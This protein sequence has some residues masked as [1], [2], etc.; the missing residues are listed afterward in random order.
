MK[1]QNF[2]KSANIN[3]D[4]KMITISDKK[5]EE[6]IANG[7]FLSRLYDRLKVDHLV[8]PSLSNRVPD[9]MPI[10]NYYISKFNSR[11]IRFKFL[12]ISYI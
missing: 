1:I 12:K 6:E 2:F 10:L 7:N 9:I 4:H 8:C 3:L 11:S 5:L